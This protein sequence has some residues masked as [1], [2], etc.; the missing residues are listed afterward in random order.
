M[1]SNF[2]PDVGAT[3]SLS[4]TTTTSNVAIHSAVVQGSKDVLIQNAGTEVVFVNF[5]LAGVAATTADLPILG[6]QGFIVN[7]GG[8]T[9]AAAITATGTATV[10][11]CTGHGS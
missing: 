4:V 8:Y 6:G 3:K 10:Y 1:V 5:G 11:F 7:Q 9:H 2:T